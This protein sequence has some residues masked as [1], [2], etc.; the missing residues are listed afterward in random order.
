MTNDKKTNC[1][2]PSESRTNSIDELRKLADERFKASEEKAAENERKAHVL[3]SLWNKANK[4]TLAR[5]KDSFTKLTIAGIDKYRRVSMLF[6]FVFG[7]TENGFWCEYRNGRKTTILQ[8]GI[9]ARFWEDYSYK[10]INPEE[11][12]REV[13]LDSLEFWASSPKT[14]E[15]VDGKTFPHCLA[16]KIEETAKRLRLKKVAR[17]TANCQLG[18]ETC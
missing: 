1:F 18:E 3:S 17:A 11:L 14:D 5:V 10:C 12:I 4:E 6:A 13:Y 8:K 16:T 7:E 15:N 2:I 9:V